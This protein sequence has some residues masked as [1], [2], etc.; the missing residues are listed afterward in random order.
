MAG[1]GTAGSVAAPAVPP[2]AAV[3]GAGVSVGRGLGVKVGST[4]RV[5]ATV[6]AVPGAGTPPPQSA[7]PT[8]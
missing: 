2:A 3:A 4:T 6:T 1:G 7:L 5:G 8:K